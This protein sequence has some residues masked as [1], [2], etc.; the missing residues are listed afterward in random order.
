MTT[1]FEIEIYS[2]VQVV[3]LLFTVNNEQTVNW[4]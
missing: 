4:N 1:Q 3:N 2:M